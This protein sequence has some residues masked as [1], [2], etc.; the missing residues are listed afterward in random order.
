MLSGRWW[1]SGGR[2]RLH[3][4]VGSLSPGPWG[5]GDSRGLQSQ[6]PTSFLVVGATPCPHWKQDRINLILP[7]PPHTPGLQRGA[8]AQMPGP[9]REGKD[10]GS[11]AESS[12]E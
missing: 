6:E 5:V 10:A 11:K 1:G 12:R 2:H 3:D 8:S 7:I 4:E 9:L